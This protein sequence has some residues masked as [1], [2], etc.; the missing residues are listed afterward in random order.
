VVWIKDLMLAA[1]IGQRRHRHCWLTS[2]T[3]IRAAVMTMAVLHGVSGQQACASH[4]SGGAYLGATH[5]YD[6]RSVAVHKRSFTASTRWSMF[7]RGTSD[8]LHGTIVH[9]AEQI[10]DDKGNLSRAP[11]R[12]PA[13]RGSPFDEASGC[14]RAGGASLPPMWP[15]WDSAWA[16][17]L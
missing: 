12:S 14:S 17:V 1:G 10:R 5:F 11:H 7:R 15:W 13:V 2:P 3:A 9:G 16:P 6:P 4:R 8:A